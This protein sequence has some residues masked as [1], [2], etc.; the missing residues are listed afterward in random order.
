M[1]LHYILLIAAA[2][3][4]N[5]G[6]TVNPYYSQYVNHD[7]LTSGSFYDSDCPVTRHKV[8]VLGE[9]LLWSTNRASAFEVCVHTSPNNAVNM[10]DESEPVTM[11]LTLS[12]YDSHDDFVSSGFST[13]E[14]AMPGDDVGDNKGNI[15]CVEIG[16]CLV[17]S[18]A[19][20]KLH[21][22]SSIFADISINN[23][24][25]ID[26][27][28]QEKFQRVRPDVV[29]MGTMIV[30][31]ETEI[32]DC[33]VYELPY[34]GPITVVRTITNEFNDTS[35]NGTDGEGNDLRRRQLY[36]GHVMRP[37]KA[38]HL[39]T[40]KEEPVQLTEQ[41]E[42]STQHHLSC[43][44]SEAAESVAKLLTRKSPP[45]LKFNSQGKPQTEHITVKITEDRKEGT[46]RRSS[47]EAA[48]GLKFSVL[49]AVLLSFTF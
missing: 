24:N 1:K 12:F 39:E 27:S 36:L 32:E 29:A 25:I 48:T 33:M 16:L 13:I 35:I 42:S 30:L 38:L 49:L 45:A 44:K 14:I 5:D 4:C 15:I 23:L 6:A 41:V 34:S 3:E 37:A 47:G 31:P 9:G 19:Q 17:L 21:R 40:P 43:L 28:K 22:E 8:R 26:S 18:L 11:N 2:K 10:C 7:S 46:G 20:G